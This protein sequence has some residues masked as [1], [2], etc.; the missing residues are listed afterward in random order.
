MTAIDL[1]GRCFGRWTVI[2]RAGRNRHRQQLWHCRCECGAEK[3]IATQDLR[4]GDSRSCGC[5][6]AEQLAARN[7]ARAGR[8]MT[9]D[10]QRKR[11]LVRNRRPRPPCDCAWCG[12][13]IAAPVKNQKY[14]GP[15]CAWE[16]VKASDRADGH[17]RRA[18]LT[19]SQLAARKQYRE[20]WLR[21][22]AAAELAA[23]KGR[24]TRDTIDPITDP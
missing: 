1:T 23:V 16:S 6:R 8:G 11:N 22:R 3:E 5:L 21:Q 2:R 18:R 13:R 24:L 15:D 20:E 4:G 9:P 14:C 7:K 17:E 12:E 10:E 19:V